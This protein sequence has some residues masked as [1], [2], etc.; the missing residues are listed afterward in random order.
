MGQFRYDGKRFHVDD[1]TGYEKRRQIE[2]R[3]QDQTYP[4]TRPQVERSKRHIQKKQ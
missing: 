4:R 3:E 1:N 2:K